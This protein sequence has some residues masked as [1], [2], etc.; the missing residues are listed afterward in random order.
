MEK[1]ELTAKDSSIAF[2]I[3]L[4]LNIVGSTIFVIIFAAIASIVMKKQFDITEFNKNAY[5][6]AILAIFVSSFNLLTFLLVNK[7]KNNTITF[8]P[9]VSKILIFI[10][11]GAALNILLT[12]IINV[13][14]YGLDKLGVPAHNLGYTLD[15]Q[16]YIISLFSLALL[17]AIFEELLFRGLI[18]KGLKKYGKAFSIITT[19]LMF[20]LFHMSI[21]QTLFPILFGLTL[22]FVMYKENNL[23]YCIILHFMNNFTTL[24]LSY[25]NIS[26]DF[27]MLAYIIVA[28]AIAVMYLAIILTLTIKNNIKESPLLK[29]EKTYLYSTLAIS[30]VVWIF[31]GII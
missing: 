11:L 1:R 16:N 12:P 9:K 3:S 27:N 23:I 21:R 13:L 31:I 17:P 8:K 14:D 29:N 25:L 15:T 5:L 24:T 2:C 7:N 10:I 26:I 6:Y 4:L 28:I 18:F 19:T 30:F 20:T 22:G